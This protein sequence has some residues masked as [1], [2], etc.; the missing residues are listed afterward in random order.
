MKIRR[1]LALAAPML[2]A[3]AAQAAADRQRTIGSWLVESVAEDDGGRTVRLSRWERGYSLHYQIWYWRGNS[4]TFRRAEIV[5]GNCARGGEEGLDDTANPGAA[6]V[7]AA[8]ME[9]LGWCEVP[10]RHVAAAL[11]GFER[12]FNLADAWGLEAEAATA[13]EAEAIA[14]YGSEPQ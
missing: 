12:A 10:P 11:Q 13:A 2:A 3:T 8:L 4:R 7:R 1:A 6:A 5:W 14:N 9:R